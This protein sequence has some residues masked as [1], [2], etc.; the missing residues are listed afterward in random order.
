MISFSSRLTWLHLAKICITF[1][2][3]IMMSACGF[4]P[5]WGVRDPFAR[6]EKFDVNKDSAIK[7]CYSVIRI[8]DITTTG[9]SKVDYSY[10][11]SNFVLFEYSLKNALDTLLKQRF[12]LASERE[13]TAYILDIQYAYD[14]NPFFVRRNASA[15][16]AKI[17]LQLNYRLKA[18]KSDEVLLKKTIILIDSFSISDASYEYM[19]LSEDIVLSLANYAA[20]RIVNELVIYTK[21]K[22]YDTDKHIVD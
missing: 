11:K 21:N 9:F 6:K 12:Q 7:N 14:I 20:N 18:E 5:L 13:L 22:L 16:R 17:K 15:Q 10:A 3:V 4:R 19:V 8:G 1:I 2:V